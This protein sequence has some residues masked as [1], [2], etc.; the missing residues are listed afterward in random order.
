[1]DTEDIRKFERW[2]KSKGLSRATIESY[3]NC[4]DYYHRQGYKMDTPS[5]CQWKEEEIRRV[6]AGTV[7]LRVHALNKYSEYLRLRFRLKPLKVDVPDYIDDE[8]AVPMYQ[9]L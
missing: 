9:R 2:M 4:I 1:M 5:L 8:I 6:S 7:N 3:S